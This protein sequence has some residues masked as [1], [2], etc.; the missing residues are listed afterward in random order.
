[1]KRLTRK[2]QAMNFDTKTKAYIEVNQH[3]ANELFAIARQHRITYMALNERAMNMYKPILEWF[4]TKKQYDDLIKYVYDNIPDCVER[5]L[6]L[7]TIINRQ[8]KEEQ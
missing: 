8:E 7:H 3:H 2:W 6:Y 5:V 1:M 4:E